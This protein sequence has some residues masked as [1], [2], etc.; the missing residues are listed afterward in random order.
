[1]ERIA[2]NPPS[3]TSNSLADDPELIADFVSESREHLSNI[4]NVLLALERN[5]RDPE[6]IH[7]LFRAFHTIKG[8]AGFLGFPSIQAVAH[9]VETVL[10]SARESRLQIGPA[11]IDVILQSGDYLNREI[12]SVE[13]D[14]PPAPC[15]E[16]IA[17]I[18]SL[19]ETPAG[20][21]G[22]P[23]V[24]GLRAIQE[25]MGAAEMEARPEGDHRHTP[26]A[27]LVKYDARLV[28]VD[29]A[30]LDYLIEMTGEMVIALSLV[31]YNPAMAA[32]ANSR[33]LRDFSQLARIGEQVQ[34]SALSMRMA[35]IRSLFQKIAR[36]VRDLSRQE[37]KQVELET[38]GE[39]TELD[40]NMVEELTDP[41]MHMIRN[42]IDHGIGCA[43][44]RVA[45]S[46]PAVGRITLRA[47]HQS[48]QI[49]IEVADDGRGLDR[50][51]I[52][53]TAA[54]RGRIDG[55][56]KLSDA[57]VFNL[58]FDP[59]F[60]TAERISDMSGRGVGM[61]VVK[62]QIQKLRGVIEIQSSPGRGTAFFLKLPLTLA[63]IDGFIVSVGIERY[64]VP[65]F[66]IR[67][68]IRPVR[69]AITTVQSRAELVRVRDRLLPLIRL[70]KLFG[71][72][73]R[74]EDPCESLL[75]VCESNGKRFCLMVD[76]FTGKQE[77]VSKSMGE[78]FKSISFTAGS[79][80]L[81]DGRVGLILDTAAIFRDWANA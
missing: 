50:D 30:K 68:M 14:V 43:E 26:N 54:G 1:M 19:Y 59:G 69:E 62:R 5:P 52:I 67:E 38:S 71:V 7:A 23:V 39:D 55:A 58:I 2:Q 9:E 25:A 44:E 45:A 51:K 12:G 4:E 17:K 24:A 36:L 41:L 66:A 10:D 56:T 72:T 18:R 21:L 77:V 32:M 80:I 64:V 40:R 42:A 65:V 46:K 61:D 3:T 13:A 48:G 22:E 53:S 35:P 34:K 33:L 73:A 15:V 76:E 11:V 29:T 16:L 28:K 47:Y 60:S 49:V 79:A 31:R 6:P 37:G 75:I 27:H 20:G 78:A 57:E 8:L 81:G 70:H 74:S 63:I